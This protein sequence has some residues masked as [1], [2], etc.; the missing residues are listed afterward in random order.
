M[1]YKHCV[2]STCDPDDEPG[3]RIRDVC[4]IRRF[5]SVVSSG[6]QWLKLRDVFAADF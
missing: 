3:W 2:L 4:G 1:M 5:R 6:A